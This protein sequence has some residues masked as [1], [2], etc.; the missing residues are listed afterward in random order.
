MKVITLD[1]STPN[2]R[3]GRGGGRRRSDLPARPTTAPHCPRCQESVTILAGEG[4]GG[5]WFVCSACDHL[6]D[7][8]VV[9]NRTMAELEAE[10]TVAAAFER[11]AISSWWRAALRRSH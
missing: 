6:W 4:Q 5:W 9:L 10:V 3:H 8:R 2:R 1:R 11:P 7:Q